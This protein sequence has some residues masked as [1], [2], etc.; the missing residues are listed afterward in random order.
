MTKKIE[1]KYSELEEVLF[2]LLRGRVFHVTDE[3]TFND[4]IRNGWIH[5]N[6][7][8][9]FAFALGQPGDSY[10]RKRG[11]VSLFDLHT[12]MDAPVKEALTGYYFLKLFRSE[13]TR[14]VL[15]LAESVW[16]S[17]ISWKHASQ[18]VG[19]KEVYI[20]F[21]EA[22]YPG[23]IPLHLISDMLIVS[24]QSAPSRSSQVIAQ[25]QDSPKAK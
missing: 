13:T 16:G 23:D 18:E 8:G 5:S 11:W 20:P 19:G 17:L 2:P 7:Q 1:C 3:V 10:G 14:A 4:L 24:V 15:F 21:V 22:W 12:A 25:D 9:Q 6:Q